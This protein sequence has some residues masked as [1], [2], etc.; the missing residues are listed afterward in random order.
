MKEFFDGV[1]RMCVALNKLVRPYLTFFIA[2]IYNVLLAWAV[3]A[4]KLSIR[5]YIVSV[6]PTN[7]MI[8]GFWFAEKAALKDPKTGQDTSKGE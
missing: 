2:T 8:I 3:V 6:G 1:C 7:A 4:D 5:D